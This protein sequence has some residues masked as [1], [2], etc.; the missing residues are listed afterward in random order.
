MNKLNSDNK[1]SSNIAVLLYTH[2][3]VDDTRINM[4]IIRRCWKKLNLLNDVLLL[5]AFNGE[6]EWWPQKYLED[7]LLYLDNASHLQG[8]E[9]LINEGISYL[10]TKYPNIDYVIILA[11]D[12]WCV[13]PNYIEKLIRTMQHDQKYI[14][15]CAW[16]SKKNNNVLNVG[17]ALDFLIVDFKWS[18]DNNLFPIGY[19]NFVDSYWEIFSYQNMTIYPEKV[20]ALRFKQ[21]ILKS[22][23]HTSELLIKKI[24]ADRIAFMREREPIHTTKYRYPFFK[25]EKQRKMY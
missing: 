1:K 4:E 2:N 25:K 14:A 9:F 20:F 11:A 12:T 8:A 3:R 16:G 6:K 23:N 5:H 22:N 18:R 19:K 13:M 24:L 21:A 7:E 15:T 10:Q 17:M